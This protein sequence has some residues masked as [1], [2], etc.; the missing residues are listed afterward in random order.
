MRHLRRTRGAFVE[1]RRWAPLGQGHHRQ[2]LPVRQSQKRPATGLRERSESRTGPLGGATSDDVG[3]HA[4]TKPEP[5]GSAS[6]AAAVPGIHPYAAGGPDAVGRNGNPMAFPTG[7]SGETAGYGPPEPCAVPPLP[8]FRSLGPRMSLARPGD[9]DRCAACGR[10]GTPWRG[11]SCLAPKSYA[12]RDGRH[13]RG[14][15]G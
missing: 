2:S 15:L 13:R 12:G 8:R 3:G 7:R 1:D 11:P 10:P 14:P 5:H 4:A 9:G 6:A